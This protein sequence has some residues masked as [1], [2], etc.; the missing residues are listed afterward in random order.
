MEGE[1]KE[2]SKC[3]SASGQRPKSW[4]HL[5]M[6][7]RLPGRDR[8]S[9]QRTAPGGC[10]QHHGQL[11]PPPHRCPITAPQHRQPPASCAPLQTMLPPSLYVPFLI[12]IPQPA[13]RAPQIIGPVDV[14]PVHPDASLRAQPPLRK[15]SI[16]DAPPGTNHRALHSS[17][18]PAAYVPHV[19]QHTYRHAPLGTRPCTPSHRHL[20]CTCIPCPMLCTY[21]S[22]IAPTSCPIAHAPP[23]PRHTHPAL[24]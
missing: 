19:A 13:P 22:P 23:A 12:H 21:L 11:P 1:E 4:G 20:I 14:P 24:N 6:G 17:P 10:G 9:A 16:P 3:C 5:T 8:R 18:C 2:G 7:N 15:L